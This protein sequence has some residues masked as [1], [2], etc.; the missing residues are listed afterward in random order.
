[1]FTLESLKSAP[2]TFCRTTQNY[3]VCGSRC[4]PLT[5]VVAWSKKSRDA[6]FTPLYASNQ[7]SLPGW[8]HIKRGHTALLRK[9]EEWSTRMA[10]WMH[11]STGHAL[12]YIAPPWSCNGKSRFS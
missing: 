6:P 9:K 1:M 2:E 4:N 3:T 7:A 5:E 8:M 11:V 10:G 12:W